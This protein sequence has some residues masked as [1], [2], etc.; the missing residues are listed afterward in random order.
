MYQN[1]LYERK[2][3]FLFFLNPFSYQK[4]Q[5]LVNCLEKMALVTGCSESKFSSFPVRGIV[6]LCLCEVT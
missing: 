5:M 2:S 1:I 4:K 3:I 6:L